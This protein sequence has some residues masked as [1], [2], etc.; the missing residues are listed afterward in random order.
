MPRKSRTL[1]PLA[2]KE[3]ISVGA[4]Y[5][6]AIYARLSIED[7]RDKE[8]DSIDNQ[9][10][11]IE[12]YIKERPYLTYNATFI[13][14]GETG[15]NF[16]RDGFNAMMEEVKAGKINCIVV[17]D[18]SRFGRNYIETGEYL[19]KIFPFMGVRF[20]SINDGLDNEDE[21]SN[22]D[23]LI[24]SLKNLINDVYAK[25]ISAKIISSLRT[26]QENGDYIG[27]LPLYGYKKCEENYRKL[28]IDDE[29]AHIVRDIFKWKAEGMGDTLI[30]RRLNEMGIS[31]PMKRRME[32]GLVKKTG[33]SKIYL[34]RD[35]TIQLMT[36]N[37]MYIGH[38]T[39]GRQKQA[40]CDNQRVKQ[41]PKAEW[42]IVK[43]THEAIIDKA[44]FDMA[45]EARYRNTK[46]FYRNYDKSKHIRKDNHLLKGLLVC[47]CCGSKLTR[48]KTA[49]DSESYRFICAMQYKGLGT[50]CKVKSISEAYVLD[51]VLQSIKM[52]ISAATDLKAMVERLNKSAQKKNR[53]GDLLS[54]MTKLQ[55][56]I[57]RLIGLKSA[58]FETYADKLL[59]EDEYVYSKNRYSK[60]IDEA[61]ARLELLQEQSVMQSET[62]T[63]QNKWLQ[64]FTRF[65]DHHELT[66][67]M[68]NTLISRIIV[69]TSEEFNI[70]WNFKSDYDALEN[71]AKQGVRRLPT[72]NCSLMQS[73]VSV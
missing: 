69:N 61:K 31:S 23:S 34:W 44:T 68:V 12:Q 49:A 37:P 65:T 32:K 4:V 2:T 9:V 48:K 46:D 16:N 43:N 29:V 27:G 19:E 6:T 66:Y 71:Y 3:Q 67:D 30:A 22:L 11:L 59:S 38:M 72:A 7:C 58:L 33:R 57:K 42:I 73:E 52:Q 15:T 25:D 39:Q 40:L 8:S 35:K 55:N 47:G 54:S 20:I 13:D 28:V 63:P 70:V 60:Q 50:G 53:R 10:Y 26:K 18:L 5:R 64:A 62:L 45:Q 21:N 36:T 24:V 51:T 17:K 1:S 41:N 14:N 56:E